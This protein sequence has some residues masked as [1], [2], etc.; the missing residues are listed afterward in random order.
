ML[1]LLCSVA[2]LCGKSAWLLLLCQTSR[3][4]RARQC[5][6]KV[7]FHA[8]TSSRLRPVAGDPKS[9]LV[10]LMADTGQPATSIF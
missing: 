10:G 3:A 4:E 6:A 9:P 8:G 1:F 7:R 2:F 5:A